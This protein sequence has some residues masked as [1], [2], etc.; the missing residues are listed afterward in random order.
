MATKGEHMAIDIA[1][2]VR[3]AFLAGVGAVAFGTEK[4]GELAAE[5]V[6]KGELTVEQGKDLNQELTV[7]AKEAVGGA[8]DAVLKARLAAM[9]PEEREAYIDRARKLA[10]D[11]TAEEAER[12]V[13]KAERN[14]AKQ[15]ADVVEPVTVEVKDASGDA[16]AEA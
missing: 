8:Q 3:K 6:K 1:E 4:A 14:A 9:S 15:G 16:E 13:K 11:L 7:K 10:S 12:N 5:L 2:G